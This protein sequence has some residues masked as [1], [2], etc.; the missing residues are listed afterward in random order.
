MIVTTLQKADRWLGIPLCCTLT[1]LRSL[2]GRSI[3]PASAPLR[4]LLLV[5]LAEQGSTVL[6]YGAL[7]RAA[8]LVGRENVY[9][10]TLQE[11]RFILDVLDVL[12]QAN[13]ITIASDSLAA[14]LRGTLGVIRRLRRMKFD[15]A[16]D[17]EFFSRGSAALTFLSG[18]RRRVGFHAFFGGG[19]YRGNLMT[20]R[21]LYNP[22]L[23]TSQTFWTLVEALRCDPVALPT[24]GLILPPA[25][26]APAQFAP[27][28]EELAQVK[29]I[30]R[31]VT[32]GQP[33]LIL[34][35]PNA[36]DLLPLRRW[37]TERYVELAKRLLAKFPDAWIGFTGAPNEARATTELARQ[38]GSA[39]CVTFA[40]KTTLRQLLVLYTLAEVLVTNDS[41]PA[42]FATLTPIRVVTLFGPET[43][44][45]Y[46]ARSPRNTALWAGIACS[47]CVNA[48]NNRQSPCRN[49]LCLQAISVDQVFAE[50][51]RAYEQQAQRDPG[52]RPVCHP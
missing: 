20:H 10:I 14:I 7:Q 34:L 6:A 8:Q 32:G 43:P 47:P 42:H 15:A 49:N 40:G 44:H 39:R 45:L 1:C 9:F 22:H 31:G 13:V 18:A 50:A 35:N 36:S 28:P 29:E 16:I 46:A 48:Y 24:C 51:C 37:P 33:P 26:H 12:P 19:P 27:R 21:L 30:V 3:P 41:G 38:V 2:F 23:H 52:D 11:N 17:M 4:N 25:N 5:K